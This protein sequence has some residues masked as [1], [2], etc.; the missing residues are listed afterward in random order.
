MNAKLDLNHP[1]V[2][3]LVAKS[4]PLV[5]RV[6][7]KMARGLSANI[8]YDDLVQ[9]GMLGL[10]DAILR[11]T[12]A[13]AGTQ[14]ES[15][16]AQRARGAMLDGL[17][18][19]DPSSRQIRQRMR[20][21]EQA[22]QRLGHQLGRAPLES[23][24][25]C[26]LSVALPDYQRLLQDA[27]GY[28]LI[29]LDDLGDDEGFSAFIDQC[30]SRNGDPLV[31]LER[32]ALRQ[33]LLEAIKVLPKQETLVLNFYYEENLRMHE[34]GKILKLSESRVS[35]IHTQAIAILRAAFISNDKATSLLKPRQNVR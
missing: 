30:V 4:T 28:A 27:H 8:E 29:S 15:Y 35:Q 6:A 31:V 14:F 17:R 24:V 19:N 16:V 11:T 23:E 13:T 7:A 10:M 9:D 5:K 26:A 20:Q 18:L 34:I 33:T 22:I 25:A 1:D 21:V 32:A 12:K 2:L 3:Q